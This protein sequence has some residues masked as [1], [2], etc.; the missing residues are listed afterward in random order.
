MIL[1]KC[2][3]G[4]QEANWF[5]LKVRSCHERTTSLA[6]QYQGFTEFMP[7]YRVRRRWSDRMK[8]IDL[9]LFPGYVFC[10]FNSK[11]RSPVLKLPGVTGVVSF[12]QGPHPLDENE[13]ER[14]RTLVESGLPVQPWPYLHVGERVRIQS[15]ALSG[16]EGVLVQFKNE[17]RLVVSLNLLQ[18]SL[19]VEIDSDRVHSIAA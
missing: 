17:F 5:A 12:G 19:A 16:L 7:T 1:A 11:N 3:H 4:D 2:S 13:I 18:R 6:L 10:R 9:P 15:G 14:I 8:D